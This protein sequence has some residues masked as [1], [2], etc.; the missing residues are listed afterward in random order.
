MRYDRLKSDHCTDYMFANATSTRGN[1]GGQVYTNSTNWIKIYPT[2]SKGNCHETFD[3]LAHR[4]GLPLDQAKEVTMGW[5]RRKVRK[6][7]VHYKECEPYSPFQNGV[8]GGIRELKRAMKQSMVKKGRPCVHGTAAR[9]YRET[10][11]S[12]QR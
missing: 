10:C 6:A 5:M 2:V 9:N 7:G 4:E 8:E 3:L 1:N 12:T 11:A